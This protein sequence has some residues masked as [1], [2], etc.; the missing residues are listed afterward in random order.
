MWYSEEGTKGLP[1]PSPLLTVPNVTAHL[2]TASVPITVLLYTSPLLC[3]VNVPIKGLTTQHLRTHYC[4][5]HAILHC[6]HC[7]G[8]S[9]WGGRT[10]ENFP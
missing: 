10:E 5:G 4:T 9:H 3:G 1:R 7:K 8:A 6:R 2:S